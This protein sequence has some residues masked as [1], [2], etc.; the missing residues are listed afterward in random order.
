MTKLSIKKDAKKHPYE[1]NQI[2]KIITPFKS[3]SK[4]LNNIY[5]QLLIT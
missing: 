2:Y 5:Q 1:H 3:F 4:P